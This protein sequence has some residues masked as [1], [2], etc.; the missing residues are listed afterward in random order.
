MAISRLDLPVATARVAEEAVGGAVLVEAFLFGIPGNG[1]LEPVGEIREYAHTGD[2]M[3]GFDIHD[4][5]LARF[6]AVEPVFEVV[7]MGRNSF[8]QGVGHSVRVRE[9]NN[10]LVRKDTPVPAAY[11]RLPSCPV[12]DGSEIEVGRLDARLGPVD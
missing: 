7:F 10:P 9:F 5:L 2:A 3:P 12:I 6:D 4:G 11:D 8:G 1:S